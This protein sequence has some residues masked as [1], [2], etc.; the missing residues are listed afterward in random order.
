MQNSVLSP[1]VK[2]NSYSEVCESILMDGAQIG[3]HAKVRRA[4]IDKEVIV[5]PGTLIGYDLEDDRKRFTVSE[6][7]IVVIPKG[8]VLPPVSVRSIRRKWKKVASDLVV[9]LG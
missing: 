4:I 3:R 1:G 9:A 5:P 6:K 2:V 7:G 8:S